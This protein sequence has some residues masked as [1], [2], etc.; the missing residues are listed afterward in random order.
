[1]PQLG[2]FLEH[3]GASVYVRTRPRHLASMTDQNPTS[4]SNIPKRVRTKKTQMETI[5]A[6]APATPSLCAVYFNLQG[7]SFQSSAVRL[8]E[9]A[10]H[11]LWDAENR[12]FITNGLRSFTAFHR[13]QVVGTMT[14][15]VV[16][17]CGFTEAG[18]AWLYIDDGTGP[19]FPSALAKD[20]RTIAE[21]GQRHGNLQ[22]KKQNLVL[23][24]LALLKAHEDGLIEMPT[25]GVWVR[26]SMSC[27]TRAPAEIWSRTRSGGTCH[28]TPEIVELEQQEERLKGGQYRIQGRDNEQDI[29]NLTEEIKSKKT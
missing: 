23:A 7:K 3:E 14:G 1:M 12:V 9:T 19:L 20:Y 10:P 17:A 27:A 24:Q 26:T 18:K 15:Q 29:G 28:A 6:S 16:V 13:F 5:D 4:G 22:T 21:L 25:Y 8:L 2:L 11:E